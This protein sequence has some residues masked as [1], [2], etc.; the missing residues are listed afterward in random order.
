MVA[1]VY[2]AG[3]AGRVTWPTAPDH[4][5]GNDTGS[6]TYLFTECSALESKTGNDRR[7]IMAGS[8]LSFGYHEVG[9][10]TNK[11]RY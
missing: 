7:L 11:T 1:L 9:G 4:S 10:F 5:R 2:D 8:S 6:L 3:E